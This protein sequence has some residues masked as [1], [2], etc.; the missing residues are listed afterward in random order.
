MSNKILVI[1][2]DLHNLRL[3]NLVL[4]TEGFEV[5]TASSGSEG[6]SRIEAEKPDLVILDLMMPDMDG[7]EVCRRI[8][9]SPESADLPLIM[10]TAKTEVADR[11]AGLR[12]GADDYIPKPAAPAEVL[13]RVHAVLA[14][15]GRKVR[16]RGKII[17]FMGAK[18]GV[19]TSTVAVNLAVA[20]C[21]EGNGVILMDFRSHLGTVCL[22]LGLRPRESLATLLDMNPNQMYS[23]HVSSCLV[24][25]QRGLRILASP[26]EVIP[27]QNI[28]PLHAERILDSARSLAQ[29]VLLDLPVHPCPAREVALHHSDLTVLVLEP[30]PIALACARMALF[31]LETLGIGGKL[32]GMLIVNRSG[33]TMLVSLSLIRTSLPTEVLGV[34]PHALEACVSAHRQRVPLVLVYPQNP[35]AVALK[36]L[37]Q[38]LIQERILPQRRNIERDGKA[39]QNPGRR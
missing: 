28:S 26:Q 9:G 32:V 4:E 8:R 15:A 17:N 33:D 31:H 2:D 30:E 19:G 27:D 23:R 16:P 35:A 13:A 37:A 6:L 3:L 29:V 11:V 36:E 38:R 7:L 24:P 18:G 1:D 5:L 20:L 21:Q 34:I 22:Q 14:R 25:Y 39:K 12:L 10:L